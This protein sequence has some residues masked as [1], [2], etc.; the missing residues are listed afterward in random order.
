M[1][2]K[3]LVPAVAIAVSA[4]MSSVRAET[5]VFV[6]HHGGAATRA[7]AE[8]LRAT[9]GR[10]GRPDLK[11][12]FGN[13]EDRKTLPRPPQIQLYLSSGGPLHYGAI[14][15]AFMPFVFR[16]P[17]HF[18][19]FVKSDLYR[20]LRRFDQERYLG[21]GWIALGYGGFYQLFSA[22]R[23]MTE[24]KHFYERFVGGASHV[25][26]YRKFGAIPSIGAIT[27]YGGDL[28]LLAKSERLMAAVEMPLVE[29]F[30]AQLD[31]L[32]KFVNL[33]FS[34]VNG[35]L[36]YLQD[37]GN[38]PAGAR[39]RITAWVEAA[40]AACTA[41]NYAAER[42]ALDDLK[43]AGLTVVPVNRAAFSEAGWLYAMTNANIKWTTSDFDRLVQL[44]GGPKPKRLPSAV[45]ASLAP[46]ERKQFLDY[47]KAASE[48]RRTIE[49]KNVASGGIL[50]GWSASIAELANAVADVDLPEAQSAPARRGYVRP[51]LSQDK[52]LAI[53]KDVE[54]RAAQDDM[55][56]RF[57]GCASVVRDWCDAARALWKA[58]NREAANRIFTFA[59]RYA[60][61]TGR[62]GWPA[63]DFAERLH[64]LVARLAVGD[65][66]APAALARA[67]DGFQLPESLLRSNVPVAHGMRSD[68]VRYMASLAL[69]MQR[70]GNKAGMMEAF[71]RA[72]D[73]AAEL[74]GSDVASVA[75][76]YLVAGELKAARALAAQALEEADP[77]ALWKVFFEIDFLQKP[78]G[79][80]AA[81]LIETLSDK[82]QP[83]GVTGDYLSSPERSKLVEHWQGDWLDHLAIAAALYTVSGR[84]ED[85]SRIEEKARAAERKAGKSKK[86]EDFHTEL[87]T[88]RSRGYMVYT[89]PMSEP[90]GRLFE[91]IE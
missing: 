87:E 89:K 86:F 55:S 56:C 16:D 48:E 25:Q 18:D 63:S 81:R 23:A 75:K 67:M 52:V 79:E 71:A 44:G 40:A 11:I 19:A 59:E 68:K 54:R 33:D 31:K 13:D 5:V 90:Y 82:E 12:V 10:L 50:T 45:V 78:L 1:S 77:A 9:A 47:V 39:A 36:F 37:A 7:C 51:P 76:A 17:A 30:D 34:A 6:E 2:M 4:A 46:K 43:K 53:L 22:A 38:F 26:L 61:R 74:G 88:M 21:D 3:A 73:L 27:G 14:S 62:D 60:A 58:G 69:L 64:V 72:T 70:I 35:V 28:P 80:K 41:E 66:G 49:S 91:G 85:L 42:K 29:A 65:P 57:N 84:H 8:A 83:H 20:E 15:L 24:P 32:T